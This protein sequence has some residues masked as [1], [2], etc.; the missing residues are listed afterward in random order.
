MI[1]VFSKRARGMALVALCSLTAACFAD[2]FADP[3]ADAVPL[4]AMVTRYA[5]VA[6]LPGMV[7]YINPKHDPP[8]RNA[9]FRQWQVC[10]Y[11]PRTILTPEMLRLF[12]ENAMPMSVIGLPDG[13]KRSV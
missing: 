6:M 8:A 5:F 3:L 13:R 9:N 11:A 1:E 7:V 10:P 12:V 2:G 4:P